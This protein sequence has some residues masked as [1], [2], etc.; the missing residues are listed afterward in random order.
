MFVV[1]ETDIISLPNIK[2]YIIFRANIKDKLNRILVYLKNEIKAM[3]IQAEGE[4][5]IPNI[6]LNLSN[7]TAVALYNQFTN[8]TYTEE[9]DKMSKKSMYLKF[10]RAVEYIKRLQTVSKK[11]LLIGDVN[12]NWSTNGLNTECACINELN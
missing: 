7:C 6:I 4:A 1:R 10:T 5:V 3:Q 12:L 8:K 2:G 11:I 9:C